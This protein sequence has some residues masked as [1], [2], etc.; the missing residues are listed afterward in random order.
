MNNGPLITLGLLVLT[1]TIIVAASC[2]NRREVAYTHAEITLATR[3]A[4]PPHT[5]S[6]SPT[7][8]N[9]TGCWRS[10][11]DS[12]TRSADQTSRPVGWRP[13]ILS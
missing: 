8:P 11:R 10:S 4:G 5:R 6:P 13:S 2:P 7:P 1:G 3:P 12:T 9:S